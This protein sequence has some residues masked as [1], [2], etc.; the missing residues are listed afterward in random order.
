MTSSVQQ[1]QILSL[2]VPP[3][4]RE[5]TPKVSCALEDLNLLDFEPWRREEG[6]WVGEYTLLGADGN[7]FTSSGWPY[8]YDHYRGFIHLEVIGNSIKQRNVFLYPPMM[9]E[10]CSGKEGE[11]VGSGICGVNGNEKIFMADQKA[12]DCQGNLAGP[13]MDFGMKLDTETTI[14]DD[15]T[16]LYQV[17]MPD[18]SLVQNQLTSLPGNDTRVRTAQGFYLGDVQYTSFYRERKV[19]QE[20]FIQLLEE[21]RVEYNILEAD[22]CGYTS[23]GQPSGMTCDEHFNGLSIENSI[24]SGEG[25]DDL[26]G[27]SGNDSLFGNRNTNFLNGGAGDDLLRGGKGTDLL[28]GGSGDDTLIGDAGIGIYRGGLGADVYVFRTELPEI[29]EDLSAI[30]SILPGISSSVKLPHA[31]ITDFDSAKDIIG[32]TGGTTRNDLIFEDFN[33]LEKLGIN[34]SLVLPLIRDELALLAKADISIKDLDPNNDG[35]L[36][37]STIKIN[38]TNK[39]LGLLLNT[40]VS[41][42]AALPESQFITVDF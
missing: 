22:Y 32:L 27:N 20:E 39:L 12:S 6:W 16:V 10:L 38:G 29:E 37:G 34:A 24:A 7:P 19:T 35:I 42:I 5:S 40:E 30:S 4:S 2:E 33:S 26:L 41:E 31:V 13:Y 8:L 25:E 3:A 1:P 9:P 11:V 36:E 28:V 23:D 21:T 14:I 15:E 17:R 18:G